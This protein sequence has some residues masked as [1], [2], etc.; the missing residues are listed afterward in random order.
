MTGG[1]PDPFVDSAGGGNIPAWRLVG[2]PLMPDP[3]PSCRDGAG[4]VCSAAQPVLMAEN[5]VERCE[6]ISVPSSNT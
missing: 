6:N 3:R 4:S 2:D 5:A 1:E